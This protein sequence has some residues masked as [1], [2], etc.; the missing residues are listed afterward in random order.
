MGGEKLD[1]SGWLQTLEDASGPCGKDLEYDNGF[2]DL[3]KAAQGKP[4]TQFGPGE[5]PNWREVRELA[6]EL[7]SRTRDLR[8]ALIWM[9][10]AIN[11]N[12]F[13]ALPTGLQLIEGLL[14]NFWD[15]LH[16]LPDPDDGDVYARANAL[17]VLPQIDG[18]LGDLRQCAFFSIRG[19]GELRFRAVEIALGQVP[20]KPDEPAMTRDQL[21][22]MVASAILQAPELREQIDV[23]MSTLK[24]LAALMSDRFGV[25]SAPDL[26]P[27]V[28][29]VKSVQGL[30][31]AAMVESAASDE[32]DGT[33]AGPN[34]VAGAMGSPRALGQVNSRDDALRAIDMVC[35]YLERT[36]PTNPAQMMLRRARRLI[37]HNFLQLMKELAPDALNEVA[38]VM[39][40]DPDTISSEI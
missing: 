4:E 20:A 32:I 8:V 22:Q 26:K 37:N 31:P 33:T 25:E 11:L 10:S 23:S 21:S 40:V 3:N 39:G 14:T 6:E 30:L 18:V 38:R 35:D 16:P 2:L 12:G 28:S 17:A 1:I 15:H 5:P 7:M 27:I 19:V 34:L 9:R 13:S 29:L 24:S 36:E